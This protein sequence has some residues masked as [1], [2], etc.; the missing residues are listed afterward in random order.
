MWYNTMAENLTMIISHIS[1]MTIGIGQLLT[2]GIWL[3]LMEWSRKAEFSADRAGL[4]AVQS[5]EASS[6][7]LSNSSLH[8]RRSGAKSTWSRS[9]GRQ[10][11]STG[12]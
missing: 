2:M 11:S 12:S 5:I 3:S 4:L 8:P 10:R 6:A 7:A 9:T 1:E